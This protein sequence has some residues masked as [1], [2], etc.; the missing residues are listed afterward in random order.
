MRNRYCVP[1]ILASMPG[2]GL[3]GS[4]YLARAMVHE[5]IH[6]R[7]AIANRDKENGSVLNHPLGGG[8]AAWDAMERMVWADYF[9]QSRLEYFFNPDRP[10]GARLGELAGEYE[11]DCCKP[12]LS[13]SMKKAMHDLG[14][15]F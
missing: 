1:R 4:A 7:E 5:W 13:D 8:S 6:K 9:D 2:A 14:A 12:A 11:G 10:L 3:R 15:E